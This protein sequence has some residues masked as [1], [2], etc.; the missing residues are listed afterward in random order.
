MKCPEGMKGDGVTCED[1]NECLEE[2]PCD[3]LTRCINLQPGY[4]C[5]ACP[6]GYDGSAVTGRGPSKFKNF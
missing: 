4:R 6:D 2:N 5:S 1:I 3:R